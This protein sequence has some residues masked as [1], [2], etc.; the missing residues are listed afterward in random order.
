MGPELQC[1]LKKQKI[2]QQP[3]LLLYGH[4][5]GSGRSLGYL[6]KSCQLV[7]RRIQK[8]H[9]ASKNRPESTAYKSYGPN[10]DEPASLRK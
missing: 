5:I 8:S 1:T 7:T 4:S 10:N 6:S 9:L 3:R 2:F